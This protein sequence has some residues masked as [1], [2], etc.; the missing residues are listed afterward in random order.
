MQTIELTTEHKEKILEMAKVLFVGQ[1]INN[2]I[3]ERVL[4]S[5]QRGN[6]HYHSSE[7]NKIFIYIATNYGFPIDIIHWFEFCLIYVLPKLNCKPIW[8]DNIYEDAVLHSEHIVDYLY[9]D[10]KK[11]KQC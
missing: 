7:E 1:T 8:S 3:I 6:C 4:F 2:K 5:D 9:I 10:F 11:L